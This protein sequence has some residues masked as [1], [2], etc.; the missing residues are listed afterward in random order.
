MKFLTFVAGTYHPSEMNDNWRRYMTTAAMSCIPYL[1]KETSQ[2][3][4]CG[5]NFNP[6][7][8]PAFF[9]N[10][11]TA[12]CS[13]VNK[14]MPPKAFKEQADETADMAMLLMRQGRF[15]MNLLTPYA[16]EAGHLGRSRFADEHWVGSH[17][18]LRP[19]DWAPYPHLMKWI[20]PSFERINQP[21]SWSMAPRRSIQDDWI[22]LGG[23]NQKI[24]MV[25]D[26]DWRS[27][28]FFLI[29]GTLW[30]WLVRYQQLPPE[31]SYV[32]RWF[33]DGQEWLDRYRGFN[34]SSRLMLYFLETAMSGQSAMEESTNSTALYST[35]RRTFFV[36]LKASQDSRFE[37]AVKQRLEAIAQ[38]SP[39]A[40]IFYGIYNDF[41]N[42][43]T[44]T[45]ACPSTLDCRPLEVDRHGMDSVI[46]TRLHEYC[47]INPELKVGFSR[48]VADWHS[49]LASLR[50]EQTRIAAGECWQTD[51]DICTRKPKS[52][53]G[54]PFPVPAIWLA[55]CQYIKE[56]ETP[57]EYAARMSEFHWALG[58]SFGQRWILSSGNV[59]RCHIDS[60]AGV[61]ERVKSS[62]SFFRPSNKPLLTPLN[63]MVGKQ[64]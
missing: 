63:S 58:T 38:G 19:C 50:R 20:H 40:T 53:P 35:P 30:K 7:W 57:N 43:T 62:S 49:P 6:I 10:I 14:L 54:Q 37:L 8:T 47:T 33:P 45:V 15:T 56:L 32:W 23:R 29:R 3:N 41:S 46:L 48:V 52:Q 26:V 44:A 4:A 21:L 31:A 24:R 27:R 22:F 61:V 59:S 17:P 36:H 28:E 11:W 16:E 2:C 25:L 34:Q 12:Q 60:E 39:G 1:S 51:C 9:G 42:K 13:Y 18:D 64:D 55:S 5:F